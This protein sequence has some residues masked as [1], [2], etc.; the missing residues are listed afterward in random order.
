[1]NQRKKHSV[2]TV[3]I[4]DT[5]LHTYM[6]HRATKEPGQHHRVQVFIT[7]NPGYAG[8]AELPDSIFWKLQGGWWFWMGPWDALGVVGSFCLAKPLNHSTTDLFR[9]FFESSA[10][11]PQAEKS[12]TPNIQSRYLGDSR[13]NSRFKF[14]EPF[15]CLSRAGNVQ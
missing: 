2:Y 5:Y 9:S 7:M 1:M 14:V 10:G 3:C 4:V 8:R 15:D 13:N 11:L 6:S 12:S